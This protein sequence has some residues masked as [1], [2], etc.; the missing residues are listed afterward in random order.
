MARAKAKA[1]ADAETKA[2][3]YK[4]TSMAETTCFSM[5]LY[6]HFASEHDKY[7]L[8]LSHLKAFWR[9][10][11]GAKSAFKQVFSLD[12]PCSLGVNVT[13]PMRINML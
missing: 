9:F 2:N 7:D 1:Q 12:A 3:K 8:Q 11:P 5:F 6:T 13:K 10:Y 4:Q